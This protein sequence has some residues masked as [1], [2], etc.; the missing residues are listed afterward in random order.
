[1]HQEKAYRDGG[2]LFPLFSARFEQPRFRRNGR[3]SCPLRKALVMLFRG[4]M[5]KRISHA[6]AV[7]EG[8]ENR[9][10]HEKGVRR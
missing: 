7:P 10:L 1:M 8:K 6:F 5:S 9:T 3:T 2:R 4:E